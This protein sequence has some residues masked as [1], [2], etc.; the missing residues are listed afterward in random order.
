MPA[1]SQQDNNPNV[2]GGFIDSDSTR[3][4][5]ITGVYVSMGGTLRQLDLADAFY[6]TINGKNLATKKSDIVTALE[7]IS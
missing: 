7:A 5:N 1:S 6:T 3:D 2:N 4:E